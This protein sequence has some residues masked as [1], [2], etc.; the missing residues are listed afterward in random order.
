MVALLGVCALVFPAAA[1]ASDA[2]VR[3]TLRLGVAEIASTPDAKQLRRRLVV[4]IASLRCAHATAAAG[5]RGRALALRGFTA[6]LRGVETQLSMRIHDSGRLEAAVR[7]AKRADRHLDRGA[8]LLRAAG[9][10]L[11][12]RVGRVGGR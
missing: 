9:R 5:R 7:D 1:V 4:T 6:T 11:G 2:S 3:Q 10:A 12:V 8:R